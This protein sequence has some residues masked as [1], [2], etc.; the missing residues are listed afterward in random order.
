MNPTDPLSTNL[1]E[2]RRSKRHQVS[3]KVSL[4]LKTVAVEGLS[5]N[6]SRTGIL[7]YTDQPVRVV[8]EFEEEGSARRRS[9]TLVRCERIKGDRRGW[10]VEF[11]E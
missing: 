1:S 9:G 5:E 10:A 11:D 4:N 8:V 3:G 2:R 7:F 6:L